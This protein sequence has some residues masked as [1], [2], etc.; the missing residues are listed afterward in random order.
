MSE[1]EVSALFDE[2][3]LPVG[4]VKLTTTDALR[5]GPVA[6]LEHVPKKL[7]DFFDSNMLLL[8]DFELRQMIPFDR[9]AL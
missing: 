8:F 6:L 3:E 1:V 4:E 5:S 2:G 9:D 7:L